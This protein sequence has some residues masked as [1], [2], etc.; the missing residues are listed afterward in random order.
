MCLKLRILA[1]EHSPGCE[2]EEV[3][4]ATP[5]SEADDAEDAEDVVLEAFLKPSGESTL[6]PPP[7]LDWLC[8]SDDLKHEE[9]LCQI[10]R[11]HLSGYIDKVSHIL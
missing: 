9:E 8:V 7:P 3:E 1:S 5:D 6:S 11:D 10:T 4:E 2:L